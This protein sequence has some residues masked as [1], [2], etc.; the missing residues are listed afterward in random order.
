MSI[1]SKTYSSRSNSVAGLP[2]V[3]DIFSPIAKEDRPLSTPALI[4]E[5]RRSLVACAL[6]CRLKIEESLHGKPSAR[7]TGPACH[8]AEFLR[9]SSAYLVV[10]SAK[11]FH[12]NGE[13]HISAIYTM[14]PEDG[15]Q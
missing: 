7:I 15:V 1:L 3:A 6:H 13:I 11:P 2:S 4:Q 12:M 5:Q 9:K 10:G 8:H 14:D